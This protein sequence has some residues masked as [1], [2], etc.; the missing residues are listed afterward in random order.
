MGLIEI[1]FCS[2]EVAFQKADLLLIMA[3]SQGVVAVPVTPLL[4]GRDDGGLLWA[5]E[6]EMRMEVA[7]PMLVVPF[8]RECR[9]IFEWRKNVL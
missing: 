2:S 7:A 1:E 3:R 5:K 4:L 6:F 9:M 8:E